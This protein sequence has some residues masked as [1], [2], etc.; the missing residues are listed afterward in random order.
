[1][2]YTVSNNTA[3]PADINSNLNPYQH[4]ID[5]EHQSVT[6]DPSL[7]VQNVALPL[8]IL[9]GIGSLA[10][11]GSCFHRGSELPGIPSFGSQPDAVLDVSSR[12]FLI[13]AALN[14]V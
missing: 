10:L 9:V 13:V 5:T 6:R 14:H 3:Q 2:A 8:G 1:M 12:Y 7:V 4:S 11:R